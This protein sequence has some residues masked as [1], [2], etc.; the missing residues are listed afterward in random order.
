MVLAVRVQPGSPPRAAADSGQAPSLP[1]EDGP[2]THSL[3]PS[4]P[5]AGKFIPE[6]NLGALR[7]LRHRGGVIGGGG[8]EMGKLGA[9]RATNQLQ[10]KAY[11]TTP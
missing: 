11:T 7:Q 5:S 4:P 8:T 9:P 2:W 1:S 10:K 6:S 3:A